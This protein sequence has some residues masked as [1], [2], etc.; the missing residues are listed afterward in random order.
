VSCVLRSSNVACCERTRRW[1]LWLAPVRAVIVPVGESQVEYA[2][3]LRST[4]LRGTTRDEDSN[5]D[6]VYAVEMLT[7]ASVS[8][9]V[10]E[11]TSMLVPY[12]LVV[13][14]QEVHTVRRC[15]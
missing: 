11:A 4:L 2:S 15:R 5:F 9:R 7:D 13:G 6:E 8:K 1:P 12:V 14:E 10:R 3:Q